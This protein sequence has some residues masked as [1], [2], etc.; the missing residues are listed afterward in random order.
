VS[1]LAVIV[2]SW[3]GF[4]ANISTNLP[5]DV[6]LTQT[7]FEHWEARVWAAYTLIFS[8][9]MFRQPPQLYIRP[10]DPW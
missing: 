10:A 2:R 1:A 9:Y 5:Q 7:T 8:D 3:P 6:N 4:P